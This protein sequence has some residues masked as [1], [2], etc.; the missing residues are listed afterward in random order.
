MINFQRFLISFGILP[1]VIRHNVRVAPFFRS[2]ELLIETN[3]R[4]LRNGFKEP[5]KKS[6]T[7]S[8]V[9]IFTFWNFFLFAFADCFFVFLVE[10]DSKG[11]AYFYW[12]RQQE[13]R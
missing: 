3:P 9:G 7:N 10:V 8:L 4:I 1:F 5:V 13:F 12:L 2:S 6:Q 11:C